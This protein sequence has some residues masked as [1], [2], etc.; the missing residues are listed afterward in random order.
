MKRFVLI[1]TTRGDELIS[2]RRDVVADS[3]DRKTLENLRRS[4]ANE[5]KAYL[6]AHPLPWW[7]MAGVIDSEEIQQVES[8]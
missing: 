7:A 6:A 5:R 4:R 1:S 8:V 2:S 3:A